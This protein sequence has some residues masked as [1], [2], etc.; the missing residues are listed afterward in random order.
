MLE[1]QPKGRLSTGHLIAGR[2]ASKTNAPA[3][4]WNRD[5]KKCE[6]RRYF[7]SFHSRP[8]ARMISDSLEVEKQRE[9]ETKNGA[10]ARFE[11]GTSKSLQ[12]LTFCFPGRPLDFTPRVR[13][14]WKE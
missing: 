7:F 4:P 5:I 11:P 10:H 14:E 8:P 6:L 1:K 3:M 9:N 12:K 13:R 2:D